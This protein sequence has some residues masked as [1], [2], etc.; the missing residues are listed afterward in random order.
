MK[1]A[2]GHSIASPR[3]R[4][5]LSFYGWRI[6]LVVFLMMVASSGLCFYNISVLME[7]LISQRGFSVSL[8]STATGLFFL[9]SGVTGLAVAWAIERYDI[10]ICLTV[11]VAICSVALAGLGMITES[12]QLLLVFMAFGMGFSA[13]SLL[14]GTTLVTRWFTAQRSIAMS[15]ATTGLSVG[16]VLITPI[17]AFAIQAQGLSAVLPLLGLA[18]AALVIPLIWLVVRPSP[19]AMG[20]TPYGSDALSQVKSG[21]GGSTGFTDAVRSLFFRRLALA[22]ALVMMAQVGAIAHMFNMVTERANSDIAALLVSIMAATSVIG[23][24]CGGV[25][26]T[27]VSLRTFTAVLIVVQG[28]ALLALAYADR[29]TLLVA[30]TIGFGIT[31]GNLLMLQPL[32]LAAKF[33]VGAFSRIYSVNQLVTTLGVASGPAAM[34]Y[35]HAASGDYDLSFTVVGGISLFAVFIFI[36]A[37]TIEEPS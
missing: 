19:A 16:G 32:I 26:A 23:R 8:T 33:G 36:A 7:A 35:L 4:P 1:D 10:R 37:G 5:D 20:L 22:Y 27:I 15:I 24:L 2:G 31:T 18:Y 6:V 9:S 25:L 13:A 14:P 30:A 11:G 3:R 12:W 17:V 28:L 21:D 34:G 29:P